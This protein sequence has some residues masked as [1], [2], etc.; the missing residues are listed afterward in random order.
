MSAHLVGGIT[1]AVRLGVCMSRLRRDVPHGLVVGRQPALQRQALV[2]VGGER[3]IGLE[4][5]AEQ[6]YQFNATYVMRIRLRRQYLL[7]QKSSV[8]SIF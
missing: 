2:E 5:L 6:R 7:L 4:Q 1:A 8:E 3:G